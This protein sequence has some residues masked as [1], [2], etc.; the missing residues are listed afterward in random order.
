MKGVFVIFAISLWGVLP[1]RGETGV[2][3]DAA[4][5]CEKIPM[6]SI[7]NDTISL[8]SHHEARLLNW[9][10]QGMLENF[11][12]ENKRVLF[13]KGAAG[14]TIMTKQEYFDKYKGRDSVWIPRFDCCDV[15]SA[16]TAQEVGYD[17]VISVATKKRITDRHVKSLLKRRKNLF[18]H[19]VLMF[20]G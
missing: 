2:R 1:C 18:D 16:K 5:S 8:L 9:V 17:A 20:V 12:L 7:G 6:D 14:T 10:F 13:V 3:D 4:I 19:L 15:L 11:S